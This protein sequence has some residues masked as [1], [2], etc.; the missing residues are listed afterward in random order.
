MRGVKRWNRGERRRVL[1]VWR[2]PRRLRCHGPSLMPCQ[3]TDDPNDNSPLL[4]GCSRVIQA[5]AV[6][7]RLIAGANRD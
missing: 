7:D 6:L 2:W 3:Y 4:N 5:H 1:Y